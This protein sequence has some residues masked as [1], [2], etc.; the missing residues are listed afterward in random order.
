MATFFVSSSSV[1]VIIS[2]K[3]EQKSIDEDEKNQPKINVRTVDTKIT[4]TPSLSTF[5]L[6]KF[7]KKL[8]RRYIF[9]YEYLCVT[10]FKHSSLC[11]VRPN[12]E[13]KL[14]D[15]Q[16][17][18]K[19]MHNAVADK[20]IQIKTKP[21]VHRTQHRTSERKQVKKRRKKQFEITSFNGIN[22]LL[23][24]RFCFT[25][26][27]I[28]WASLCYF[29]TS[30]IKKKSIHNNNATIQVERYLVGCVCTTTTA[31]T[32]VSHAVSST[33]LTLAA[34]TQ[35][36]TCKRHRTINNAAHTHTPD[37]CKRI[38]TQFPYEW[39]YWRIQ[40]AITVQHFS[41]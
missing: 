33:E 30:G 4:K 8:S 19:R 9:V 5:V 34:L 17:F 12:W 27:V 23:V 1:F 31:P 39:I 11:M 3:I 36:P 6:S 26:T 21:N 25:A 2:T 7:F 20:K 15:K 18:I 38:R 32:V 40:N 37:R 41:T 28:I 13:F 24:V 22:L 35:K 16:S 14:L 29:I 10:H